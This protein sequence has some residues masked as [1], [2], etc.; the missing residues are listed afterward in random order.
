MKKLHFKRISILI[1][2]TLLVSIGVQIYRN[3]TQFKQNETQLSA[4]IQQSL[5]NA[6]EV[7]FADL[8]KTDVITLTENK[9]STIKLRTTGN[10]E[11]DSTENDFF[12]RIGESKVLF[13]ALEKMEAG[14]TSSLSWFGEFDTTKN[15][16]FHTKIDTLNTI[17]PHEIQNINIFRGLNAADSIRN[18]KML[19][20]QIIISI[21]RDSLDF[22]KISRL[23]KDELDRR[24]ISINYGLLQYEKDTIAG[25]FNYPELTEM[26]FSTV[27][28]S[29][30]LPRGQK[31]EMYFENTALTVL[32]RGIVDILMSVIFL[33]I[34]SGAF[35]YLYQTIK[36]QKEIAEIKED[37]IG[38]ITHEFKT[39]IA[40][41]LSAIEGIEQFNPENNPEKTKKY[42]GI[43]KGQMLKL[44]LMVEKL[45]ETAT[46]DSDQ[47][48]LQKE[49]VD[50]LPVLR[51][52][53]QKFQTLAPEK[54]IELV[55]PSHITPIQV[56]PF[57]FENVLS[58]L[59]D[60]A[61]KYGGDKVRI[62]VDQ[63]DSTRIR[64]WDNG[65]NIGSDQK[66]RVFEQFYRIP[67]GNLHDVKG[68]GIGLY[69]VKKIIEKHEG[70]IELES[71]ERSTS[72]ITIWP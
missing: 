45:L 48:I 62:T 11:F 19:T 66:E 33:L 50:P 42:L 39:P 23:V 36:N 37:L 51:S 22:E 16:R 54:E 70:K 61:L 24:D 25:S 68:F 6:L 63:G 56:D 46:L 64:I 31:L 52:L 65:G 49:E 59:L 53:V 60:N 14:D 10:A 71:S 28:K 1:A 5:D 29:T 44:N 69:Y 58:N 15:L 2:L 30:F 12:K 21:T 72:F 9:S 20:N 8:A 13:K 27:S 7:Y 43:S 57:H 17:D 18:L 47:F 32:K 4:D 40:T 35:Y 3:V 41:T 34:I 38:N 55:M 26:P 67:K